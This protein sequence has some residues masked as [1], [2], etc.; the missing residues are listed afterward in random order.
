MSNP[1]T[2]GA[3]YGF[4][5]I[6][7][8]SLTLP[9]TRAAVLGLNTWVVAFGRPTVAG[10]LAAILL[11]ITRQRPPELRYWRSFVLM[12][13]GVVI[14]VPLTFAW[15]MHSL[16]ASHGGITLGLLPLATALAAALRAHERPSPKFWLAGIAG[17]TAV[18]VYA[19]VNGAGRIEAGDVI[20]VLSVIASA[21][22]YTEGARLASVMPGWVVMC[23]ALV[24]GLPL[25]I[26]P[27]A[28]AVRTYGFAPAAGSFLGF[29]YI[30]LVSQ[31]TGM[32]I[33]YKGLSMGGIARIGQLQ[34]FQP[35][36]TMAF[37]AVLLGER[38]T[39]SMF[40]AAA[41]VVVSVAVGSRAGV[42]VPSEY[43]VE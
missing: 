14:G 20:L 18:L 19:W 29:A 5:A 42:H 22:G 37:A 1:K 21:V 17:S 23:W 25:H 9:A 28:L 31:F 8:F 15:G 38:L 24:F 12:I 27:F 32:F 34:L 40:V 10:I 30:C 7:S 13:I 41:V 43:F 11:L 2:V 33:W 6:T 39:L 35:F 3:F 16:P 26:V 36:F 4:L